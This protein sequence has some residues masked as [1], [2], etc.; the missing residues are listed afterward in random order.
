MMVADN[1][2]NWYI[3]GAPDPHWCNSRLVGEVSQ[4]QARIRG[5]QDEGM[6]TP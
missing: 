2:S 3:S 5:R 6:V 1:G 4:V